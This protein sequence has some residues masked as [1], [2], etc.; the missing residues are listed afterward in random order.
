M[1]YARAREG[2][3]TGQPLIFSVPIRAPACELS[4]SDFKSE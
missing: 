4:K 2:K 3:M 1:S